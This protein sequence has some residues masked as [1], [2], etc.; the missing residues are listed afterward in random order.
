[1]KLPGLS[2][3]AIASRLRALRV[4][5][6]DD[7]KVQEI[8]KELGV[9]AAD[10]AAVFD[11][12]KRSR[13]DVPPF[14]AKGTPSGKNALALLSLTKAMTSS[15]RWDPVGRLPVELQARLSAGDQRAIEN[16]V[17][18]LQKQVRDA[19][20][21]YVP[22]FG[23]LSLR[24]INFAELGKSSQHDVVHGRDVVNASL[25]NHDVDIL[26]STMFRGTPEH[27]GA[28][29][30]LTAKSG[31]ST[32][33]IILKVPLDRA[34]ELL[35]LV[36]AREMFAEGDLV[37]LHD[38]DGAPVS[39]AL[40]APKV[41]DV[42]QEDG[43]VVPSLVF[44]TNELGD[45]TVALQTNPF[46]DLQALRKP[47]RIG[48]TVERIAYMFAAQGGFVDKSGTAFGGPAVDYW[49]QAYL[50]ARRAAGQPVDPKIAQAIELSKLMPQGAVI[51]RIMERTDDD[52]KL[53]QD[54]LRVLFTGV[55]SPL[56]M[57][58]HQ[59]ADLDGLVRTPLGDRGDVEARLLEAAKQ[60]KRDGKL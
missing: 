50:M 38:V 9:T 3:D 53:M 59:K 1:M 54:A 14:A 19:K 23:Y 17:A 4:T 16:A 15:K 58:H 18:S 45:K 28:V 5:S 36:L 13:D 30:G 49:E 35:A 57:K 60:M 46:G 11:R 29:A 48:L 39:N 41:L 40:Y 6:R 20:L 42:T 43:R 27:P 34:E 32:P 2:P 25:P 51:D 52:A 12:T 37:D 24:T 55:V 26:V 47:D 8:A 33:G 7:V 31:A 56:A 22:V 10:V 21:D 44:T